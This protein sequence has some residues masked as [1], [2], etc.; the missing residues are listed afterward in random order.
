MSYR[1]HFWTFKKIMR[2]Y[3]K[4]YRNSKTSSVEPKTQFNLTYKTIQSEVQDL[5]REN[6]KLH[7]AYHQLKKEV[8]LNKNLPQGLRTK[9]FEKISQTNKVNTIPISDD[10]SSSI[11]GNSINNTKKNETPTTPQT[12]SIKDKD[13]DEGFDLALEYNLTACECKGDVN[14]KFKGANGTTKLKQYC[15]KAKIT[16]HNKQDTIKDV[17]AHL[18]PILN[19]R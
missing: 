9:K 4:I 7:M 15:D 10:D 16:Y 1:R 12:D 13:N 18:E 8:S 14:K 6:E 17:W 19:I 2:D 11:E 3:K 5:S